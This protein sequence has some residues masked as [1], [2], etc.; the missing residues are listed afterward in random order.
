MNA[1]NIVYFDYVMDPIFLEILEADGGFAIDRRTL[2]DPEADNFEALSR[3]HVYQISSAKDELPKPFWGAAPLFERCPN[4]LLLS[5]YG[6]GYDVCDLEAATAAGVAVVNQ[7]GGNKEGVAEHALAMMLTVA[8]KIIDADRATRRGG[9]TD[10]AAFKGIELNDKTVGIIGIGHVGTRLAKMCRGIFNCRVLAYD[11]YLTAAEIAA[12]GAEKVES[13]QALAAGSDFVS[14]NCPLTPETRGMVDAS[15]F[16]AMK[17]GAIYVATA[18][19]YIHDEAALT[20]ALASG[21]LAGAGLDVWDIEP[22]PVD[23]PILAMDNVVVSP[24]TAGVTFESRRN[25][26]KITAEQLIAVRDGK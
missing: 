17:S 5:T 18:R 16:R 19:G 24:H 12:R 10:R 20:E 21:H 22:P 4:I 25:I 26:A 9:I 8:K 7:A 15:V 23:H 13:L 3:T 6:A 14:L 11:P 1:M 2:A